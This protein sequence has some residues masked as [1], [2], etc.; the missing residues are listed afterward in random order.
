MNE[1][2]KVLVL[3][4]QRSMQNILK[5]ALKNAFDVTVAGKADEAIEVVKSSTFDFILL[6]ITLDDDRTDG[7]GVAQELEQSGYNTPMAFLSS[8]L[9]SS[10]TDDQKERAEKLKNIKFYQT[11][12]I[13][14]NELITKIHNFTS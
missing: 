14:P 5:Y 10:L 12:P 4:D 9:E 3:D 1:K 2:K 7:I 11:K 13:A 8:M 6:D